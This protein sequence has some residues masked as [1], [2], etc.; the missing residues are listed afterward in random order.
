MACSG[1]AEMKNGYTILVGKPEE[2]GPLRRPRRKRED[3]IRKE[4]WRVWIGFVWLRIG[5]GG[6]C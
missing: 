6:G 5:T 4:S 1:N 2:K 3:N